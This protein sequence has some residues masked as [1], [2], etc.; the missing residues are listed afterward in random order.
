[1]KNTLLI[2]SFLLNVLF[3]QAQEVDKADFL[4]NSGKI[5]VVVSVLV[6]VFLGIVIFLILLDRRINKIEIQNKNE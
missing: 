6:V 1:M 4:A 3:L 2:F 5:Y